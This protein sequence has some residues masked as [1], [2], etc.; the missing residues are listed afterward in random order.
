MKHRRS[1]NI[2]SKTPALIQRR[3]CCYTAADLG[4]CAG[5]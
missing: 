3:A 5:I 4:I 2:G 1:C